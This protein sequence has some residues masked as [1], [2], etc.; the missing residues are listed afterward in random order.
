MK[1]NVLEFLK[2]G[3]MAASGGPVVMAIVYG[4]L[5]RNGV[6]ESLPVGEVCTSILTVTLMAFIASGITVV[7]SIEQLPLV[8]AM[9]IHGGV[10]Y[11]DYLLVY[12]LNSWIPR[13]L[14]GI[15]VFTA[16]FVAGYAV[17]W[18]GVYLSIKA[19]TDK[20][21]KKLHGGTL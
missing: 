4:M 9:L 7:Y 19:K 14:T 16:I 20:I 10:M 5:G 15:A 3:L 17:I 6:V 18:L 2:R 21:N 8:S 11:L 1:K 13:N 12:L